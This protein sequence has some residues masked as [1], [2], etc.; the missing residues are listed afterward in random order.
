[1]GLLGRSEQES[2]CV[3]WKCSSRS[4]DNIK[5]KSKSFLRHHYILN[6]LIHL[7]FLGTENKKKVTVSEKSQGKTSEVTAND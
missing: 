4:Q 7:R 3:G 6:M 5:F 2:Y 1:M